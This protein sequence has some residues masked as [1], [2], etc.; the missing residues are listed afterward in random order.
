MIDL[1]TP[2]TNFL[3]EHL[4]WVIVFLLG[5]VVI[6][7]LKVLG[8]RAIQK[9]IGDRDVINWKNILIIV[10]FLLMVYFMLT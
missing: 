6:S 10:L 3:L 9:L 1:I 8:K 5:Y 2:L 7:L 4:A